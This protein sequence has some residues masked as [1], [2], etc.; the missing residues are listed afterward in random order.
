ML[1]F[2][3]SA[4]VLP[5]LR[6]SN[7]RAAGSVGGIMSGRWEA[8]AMALSAPWGSCRKM[9][10]R[11]STCHVR[12]PC[13]TGFETDGTETT[14]TARDDENGD[15]L[16]QHRVCLLAARTVGRTRIIITCD[17]DRWLDGCISG[18]HRLG[19]ASQQSLR[20]LDRLRGR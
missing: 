7:G 1:S 15:G 2:R 9:R 3:D 20:G 11:R 19:F 6:I 16:D 17:A 12:A 8:P 5:C 14:Q 13:E 18:R 10:R 4:D